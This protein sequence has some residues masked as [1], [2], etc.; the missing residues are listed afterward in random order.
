M[1]FKIRHFVSESIWVTLVN[2]S[3]K[4]ILVI[5]PLSDMASQIATGQQMTTLP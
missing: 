4:N 1:L 5:V 2:S 3:T